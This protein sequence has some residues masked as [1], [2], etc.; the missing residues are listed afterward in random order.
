MLTKTISL[1]KQSCE[2]ALEIIDL[3]KR[4]SGIA[5]EII[6]LSKQSCELALEIIDLGKHSGGIALETISLSKPSCELALEIQVLVSTLVSS[7][8][9]HPYGYP[10]C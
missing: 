5:L 9:D 3:G 10:W 7:F 6:S 4:S 8:G 2:L 1:S